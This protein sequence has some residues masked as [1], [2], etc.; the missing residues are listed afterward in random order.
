MTEKLLTE[1]LYQILDNQQ[2]LLK[3]ALKDPRNLWSDRTCEL[4]GIIKGQLTK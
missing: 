2:V 3:M 4:M 1:A